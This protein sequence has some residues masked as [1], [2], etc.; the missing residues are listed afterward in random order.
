[1]TINM[2]IGLMRSGKSCRLRWLNYLSPNVKHGSFSEEEDDLII[3]LH[4]LLGNRFSSFPFLLSLN[5]LFILLLLHLLH[6]SPILLQIS[7]LFNNGFARLNG[8]LGPFWQWDLNP[9]LKNLI[10]N[11][12]YGFNNIYPK[13]FTYL[14]NLFHFIILVTFC[15]ILLL[16]NPNYKITLTFL[17]KKLT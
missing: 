9:S 4:N 16:I 14:L 8:S 7:L 5:L 10:T 2:C 17:K 15:V 6:S 13:T 3:R 11:V 1:M 12:I